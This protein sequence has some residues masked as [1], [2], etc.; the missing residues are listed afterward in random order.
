L[1]CSLQRLAEPLVSCIHHTLISERAAPEMDSW[2]FQT[3]LQPW[4]GTLFA[5]LWTRHDL[6]AVAA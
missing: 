6:A 2:F 3:A 5:L 4:V 1:W